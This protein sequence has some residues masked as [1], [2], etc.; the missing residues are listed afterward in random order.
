M[1][2]YCYSREIDTIEG[3][4]TFAVI[5]YA[6]FDEAKKEDDKG[7]RDRRLE[8]A[9]KHFGLKGEGKVYQPE[10]TPQEASKTAPTKAE[11]GYNALNATPGSNTPADLP[12]S[13]NKLAGREEGKDQGGAS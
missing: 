3:K 4:E 13:P 8:L 7:I 11:A 12:D 1:G 10:P 2:R 9:D 5:E 6:S